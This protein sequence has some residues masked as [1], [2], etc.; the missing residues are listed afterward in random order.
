MNL[1]NIFKYVLLAFVGVSLVYWGYTEVQG[2]SAGARTS[3]G[4]SGSSGR[5]VVA[6]YFHGNV[7]CQS[8]VDIE[9]FS[10]E[11]IHEGFPKELESGLLKYEV[12][13]I[14]KPENQ[15][16][17]GDYELSSWALVLVEYKDGKQARWKNAE[18]VW[19][20]VLGDPSKFHDYVKEE[21][22]DF[23]AGEG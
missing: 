20:Y 12:V 8:C 11:A 9:R 17:F 13:N 15:H 22:R 7:R 3:G 6:Y 14:Q 19:E 2:R 4:A 16:Y 10:D 21:V 1:R 23:L 5:N 18:K